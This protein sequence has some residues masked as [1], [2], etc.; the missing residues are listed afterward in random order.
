VRE[1]IQEITQKIK[2]LLAAPELFPVLL[3][4]LV[5]VTSF[6]LGRL[7]ERGGGVVFEDTAHR[8]AIREAVLPQAQGYVASQGGSKYHLPWC[9]GADRILE[10]NRVWFETKEEAEAAG[11]EPAANCSGI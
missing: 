6:G 7:A 2:G 9:A 11:Y 8:V 5:G 4:L 1:R 3:V 10:E